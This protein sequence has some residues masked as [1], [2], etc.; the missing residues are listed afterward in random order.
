M[1]QS[2]KVTC[3]INFSRMSV[4]RIQCGEC[5]PRSRVTDGMENTSFIGG[6]VSFRFNK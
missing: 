2:N 4:I 1:S 6:L 3:S 5:H